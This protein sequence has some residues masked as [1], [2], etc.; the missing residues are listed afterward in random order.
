MVKCGEV[1]W[2]VAPT[3]M[4]SSPTQHSLSW[5]MQAVEAT[6]P[7]RTEGTDPGGRRIQ[8]K[9][10]AASFWSTVSSQE[11]ENSG[12]CRHKLANKFRVKGKAL[13]MCAITP[14]VYIFAVVCCTVSV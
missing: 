8:K 11:S 6:T 10:S 14:K 3:A 7:S 12:Q 5:L 13:Y 2:S 4:S 9:N 1:W